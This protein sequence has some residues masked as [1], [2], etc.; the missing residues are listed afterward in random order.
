MLTPIFKVPIL[1]PNACIQNDNSAP[2]TAVDKSIAG[3]I[4]EATL[5][6]F[7]E[8]SY[9]RCVPAFPSHVIFGPVP[10]EFPFTV[11]I[12]QSPLISAKVVPVHPDGT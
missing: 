5:V 8:P 11:V 3:V 12:S 1:S 4:A 6:V 7:P 9:S 2:S 10:P